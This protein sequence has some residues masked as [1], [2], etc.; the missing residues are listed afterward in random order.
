VVAQTADDHHNLCSR[1]LEAH[2][3]CM[4]VLLCPLFD[5]AI[6]L[7]CCGFGLEWFF[8]QFRQAAML[9]HLKLCTALL[10]PTHV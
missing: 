10:G 8:F 7:L 4:T 1:R 3:R 5:A 6:D 2:G 9:L